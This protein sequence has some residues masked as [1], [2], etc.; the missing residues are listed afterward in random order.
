ML[1]V[2]PAFSLTTDTW[3]AGF[4]GRYLSD[5]VPSGGSVVRF[6]SGSDAA[7]ERVRTGLQQ[8]AGQRNFHYRF[9]NADKPTADGRPPQL[10]R[11]ERFY[12]AVTEN[13]DWQDWA[14]EQARN[15]LERLGLHIPPGTSLGDIQA[16]A[17]ANKAD[18]D[19]LIQQYKGE[20]RRSVQDRSMTVEFRNAITNLWV[21]QLLPDTSTPGRSDVLTAWLRGETLPP[22]GARVLKGCQIYGRISSINARHYL[23]SFCEWTRRVGRAGVLI[24]L[25]F[26]AYERTGSASNR[27][28]GTLAASKSASEQGAPIEELRR[29]LQDSG[30]EAAPL[31]YSKKPYEQMLSLLRRFIDEVDRFPSLALIVLTSLQYS[32]N[33]DRVRRYTD[34]VALNTRI[35][36]EVADKNRPN[37]DAALVR[38]SEDTL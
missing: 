24:V 32:G 26:R 13:V 25:D 16:I 19:Y 18:R 11:I 37:P 3:L 2:H 7:L 35:G 34:Y 29:R 17:E 10:H 14:R 23:V 8:I 12:A 20:A 9:L 5:F 28:N 6:V 36:N 27:P 22:G 4:E 31:R 38:L 30:S 1:D 15:V 33:D 21:D